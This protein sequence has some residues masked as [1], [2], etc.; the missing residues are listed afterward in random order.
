MDGRALLEKILD[1]GGD[2][3]DKGLAHQFPGHWNTLGT[4]FPALGRAGRTKA[5][6]QQVFISGAGLLCIVFGPAAD[7]IINF[8]LDMLKSKFYFVP[9]GFS[10][11]IF[12]GI[13]ETIFVHG[14]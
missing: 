3:L 6:C 13:P 8:I 14:L 10:W 9:Q 1:F 12:F 5:L 7:C 2:L 4:G 11:G